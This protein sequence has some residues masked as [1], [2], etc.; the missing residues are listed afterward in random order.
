[1]SH[2]LEQR[3]DGTYRFVANRVPGWHMLG[4]LYTGA[5]RLDL[6]L[7][8]NLG[9]LAD[10][11]VRLA[12]EMIVIDPKTGDPINTSDWAVT[13]RNN[14]DDPAAP[15]QPLGIVSPNYVPIQNEEAF[16]FGEQLIGEGLEVE[17]A[18]SLR[19]GR[20]TWML[21]T[22][23]EAIE[24]SGDR[25]L[26]YLHVNTSHDGSMAV[27]AGLTGVRIVC[28]NTQAMALSQP[29]PRI[30]IPHFGQGVQGQIE[31]AKAALH[32][33][34]EGVAEFVQDMTV[35]MNTPVT[36]AQ[37]D[38]IVL[39]KFPSPKDDSDILTEMNQRARRESL[40]FL[41]EQAET[42][43]PIRG[44]AWG[45]A[46]AMLEWQDW[47]RG[48]NSGKNR[49]ASQVSATAEVMRRQAFQIVGSV[50]GL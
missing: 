11:D 16:A 49:A 1:M 19:G 13:L 25:V 2:E 45:A 39:R 41:Y 7:A 37:W 21:F 34:S 8:M 10:W 30:R 26:P 4:T 43:A 27:T 5:D 12:T 47:S 33:A 40:R 35:W 15:A 9:G 18:G 48:R 32:D 36:P 14:P 44:T 20:Q 46:Q 24:V 38:K 42:N 3:A 31:A 6:T 29:T 50:V 28:A 22:L 23:P 17:A